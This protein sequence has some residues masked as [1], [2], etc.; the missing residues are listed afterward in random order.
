MI[1]AYQ[2]LDRNKD[3]S[4]IL[5]DGDVVTETNVS[6]QAFVETEIGI[7][8]A[9]VLANRY[10]RMY[11]FSWQCYPYYI[12]KERL[13]EIAANII[14]TCVDKVEPRRVID[15][16]M[17][18]SLK[19]KLSDD[20][21]YQKPMLWIDT[22]NTQMTSNIFASV[23]ADRTIIDTFPNLEDDPTVPS[24]STAAALIN[25][26]LFINT[27]TADI[28]AMMLWDL[29]YLYKLPANST[30]I[31]LNRLSIKQSHE[32]NNSEWPCRQLTNIS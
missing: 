9:E 31:N 32:D 20:H 7:N 30:Y 3:I 21:Y 4:V 16:Y 10:N 12:N 27:I 14:V 1:H 26:S 5:C 17:K 6:R 23:P 8:K 28:A 29:L 2:A 25:Q 24:C 15:K 22:G 19:F 13:N 18:D 11:G